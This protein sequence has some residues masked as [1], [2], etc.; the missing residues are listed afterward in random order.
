MKKYK[1]SKRTPGAKLLRFVYLTAQENNKIF[2]G[3]FPIQEYMWCIFPMY[4]PYGVYIIIDNWKI[5]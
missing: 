1:I 5:E 2:T 4:R 3:Y